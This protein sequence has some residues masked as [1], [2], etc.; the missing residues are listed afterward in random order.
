MSYS[1]EYI[2]PLVRVAIMSEENVNMND[3]YTI[4]LDAAWLTVKSML[5][6]Y[7]KGAGHQAGEC[8]TLRRI[9]RIMKSFPDSIRNKWIAEKKVNI[10]GDYWKLK[11]ERAQHV[12]NQLLRK[13]KVLEAGLDT[14]TGKFG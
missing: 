10:N 2:Y 9:D 8:A 3:P 5:C 13:K 7:C 14:L 4:A 12:A 1:A 6:K 11:K